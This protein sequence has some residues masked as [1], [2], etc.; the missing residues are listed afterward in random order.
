MNYENIIR[1][2]ITTDGFN[3]SKKL[4]ADLAVN[5][6]KTGHVLVFVYGNCVF[7]VDAKGEFPEVHIY[8]IGVGTSAVRCYKSFV[9]DLWKKTSHKTIYA[10]TKNEKLIRFLES[11]GWA[12][13][14]KDLNGYG[15][16]T[17]QR[18]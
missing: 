10:R 11:F 1:Q 18:S 9:S 3:I 16:Y 7:T 5:E 6:I 17:L 13:A 14:G 15:I 4:L 2:R 12:L 8:S